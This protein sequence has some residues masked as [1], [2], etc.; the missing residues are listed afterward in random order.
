MMIRKKQKNDHD[1]QQRETGMKKKE[2]FIADMADEQTSDKRT[3]DSGD[4]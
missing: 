4:P 3:K 1:R 2:W